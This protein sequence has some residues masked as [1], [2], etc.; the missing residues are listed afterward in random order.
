MCVY[1]EP[2]ANRIISSGGN[3]TGAEW[4]GV[5]RRK[6]FGDIRYFFR[7]ISVAVHFVASRGLIFVEPI[8]EEVECWIFSGNRVDPI[9]ERESFFFNKH[10]EGDLWYLYIL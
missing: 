10:V 6:F 7:Y 8:R 4:S 9:A 1:V 3:A 5:R 2:E